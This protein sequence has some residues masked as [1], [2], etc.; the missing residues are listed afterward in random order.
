MNALVW[1]IPTVGEQAMVAKLFL[2][3]IFAF[4]CSMGL[5]PHGA[6]ATIIENIFEQG[7]PNQ[8]GTISF[9]STSGTSAAGVDL[10]F[11]P[12]SSADITS[13]SWTLDPSSFDVLALSLSAL[14]GD[15]PC[16]FSTAPCSNRTL[17]L[18]ASDAEPG[19]FGCSD[20]ECL[21]FAQIIPIDFVAVAPVPEPATLAVLAAGLLG[22]G[23]VRR[24][25]R[26][27]HSD[28]SV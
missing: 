26:W 25:H 5:M 23:A 16:D 2:G 4:V 13:A 12:F 21:G 27:H 20:D 1:L 6:Q 14:Q 9:P 18:S 22:L 24:R 7:T 17:H 28:A 3:A 10:S 8:L 15:N 11:A 19:Q